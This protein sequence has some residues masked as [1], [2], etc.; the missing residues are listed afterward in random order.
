ME[1]F[2]F[3]IWSILSLFI[4][5]FIYASLS[6]QSGVYI[7]AVCRGDSRKNQIALTFDDGPDPETT[8]EL[9][10]TLKRYNVRAAFFCIGK[11]ACQY[12]EIVKRMADEGHLVGNH[13]FSHAS[14]FPVLSQKKMQKELIDA[15]KVISEIIG[16]RVKYF[17]PPFGITNPMISRAVSGLG[18]T[19]IGWNLRSFD[20]FAFLGQERIQREIE[21]KLSN[22]SILLLHDDRKGCA[23]LVDSIL[24]YAERRGYLVTRVDEMDGVR[25]SSQD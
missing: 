17:R 4:L 5:F 12:P 13:T 1:T 24:Q 16:D 14:I 7:K 10:D 23:Q 19:T 18:Y 6:I 25:I 22:G 21:R 8:P 11:R 15:E 2:L 20:T 3:L 9:L